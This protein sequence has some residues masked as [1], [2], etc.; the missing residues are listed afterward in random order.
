MPKRR[1]TN[2]LFAERGRFYLLVKIDEFFSSDSTVLW[3]IFIIHMS[4][5]L[6]FLGRDY[7]P[8]GII[9]IIQN[10]SDSAESFFTK[11]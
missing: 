8:S 1:F 4:G 5:G 7:N 11:K 6:Y 10:T 3:M 9:K 2:A